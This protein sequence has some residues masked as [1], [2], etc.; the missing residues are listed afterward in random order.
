MRTGQ[1]GKTSM[2][3]LRSNKFRVIVETANPIDPCN[4]CNKESRLEI[5][6]QRNSLISILLYLWNLCNAKNCSGRY[7]PAN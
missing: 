7:S 5:N 6:L 3:H 4:V 1:P 2:E